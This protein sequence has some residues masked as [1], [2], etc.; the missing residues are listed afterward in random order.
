M[1]RGY[2]DLSPDFATDF[3]DHDVIVCRG[4]SVIVNPFGEVLAG[5]LHDEEGLLVA[6]IDLA[7]VTR[8]RYDFDAAGHYSRPDLF[9]LT[10]DTRERHPVQWR[11]TGS[12]EP[13]D[14]VGDDR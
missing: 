4:G 1:S 3:D 13:L 14:P 7:E 12:T 11:P 6:E 9:T 2:R 5:P 10:V 8:G